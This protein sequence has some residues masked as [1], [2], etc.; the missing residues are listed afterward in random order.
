VYD[1]LSLLTSH[2]TYMCKLRKPGSV[3]TSMGARKD[4]QYLK[5]TDVILFPLYAQ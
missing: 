4:V 1:I 5:R 3:N 2:V